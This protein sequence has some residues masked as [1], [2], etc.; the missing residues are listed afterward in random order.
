[1]ILKRKN[2]VNKKFISLTNLYD[3]KNL[4]PF[5][6]INKENPTLSLSPDAWNMLL[7]TPERQHFPILLST[8]EI[9]IFY[10]LSSVNR[11]FTVILMFLAVTV[12][13]SLF[14]F[15]PPSLSVYQRTS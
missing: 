12:C 5:L 13:A 7:S 15:L 14:F 8:I 10:R 2:F 6:K 11:F 4:H 9:L 3:C 1:M